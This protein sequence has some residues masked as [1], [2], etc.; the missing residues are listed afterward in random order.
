VLLPTGIAAALPNDGSLPSVRSGRRIG[1][2]GAGR[3]RQ[4]LG[5][6]LARA[7]VAAGQQLVGVTGR[8]AASS[9][10]TA[11]GLAAELQ[12]PVVAFPRLR[13]LAAAVDLLVVAAPPA[14]HAAGLRAA[15]AAGV[16]CLC[17]KP[18]LPAG[19]L[20]T[21]LELVEGFASRG[22]LLEENC[23]WP[24]VLPTLARLHPEL[25]GQ[26]LQRLVM[27][28]APAFPG[29]AMLADSLSHLLSVLQA[30]EP[31]ASLQPERVQYRGG[32]PTSERASLQFVCRG[33]HGPIEVGLELVLCPAPP[34]PAYLEINGRRSERRIGPGYVQSFVAGDRQQI[35]PDPLQALVYAVLATLEQPDLE[36]TRTRARALADRQRC[37][38]AVL[39]SCGCVRF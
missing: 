2:L 22:L 7:F 31:A 29:P 19:E 21:A 18:L 4:G 17:E 34:R 36:R 23:Q 38:D 1:I 3:T 25:V 37:Y 33:P 5:P 24:M 10:R 11:Q 16:P 26:P 15:L 6:Y 20:N 9:E 13:E 14:A 35:A 39:R 32:E 28:L 30:L 27:G 12:V 8:D